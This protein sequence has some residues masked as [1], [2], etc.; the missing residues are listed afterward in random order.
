MKKLNLLF[1][2]FTALMLFNACQS[3]FEIK[4]APK[5]SYDMV[6]S[7]YNTSSLDSIIYYMDP[8][9]Y[10]DCY[11]KK[12]DTVYN[13]I[14]TAIQGTY[15]DIPPVGDGFW[16]GYCVPSVNICV[17]I[18]KIRSIL[19]GPCPYLQSD[20]GY[21]PNN[22]DYLDF[23]VLCREDEPQLIQGKVESLITNEN[24]EVLTFNFKQINQK[25]ITYNGEQLVGDE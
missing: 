9:Y 20:Y 10:N 15:A 12:K 5:P 17:Y 2:V 19:P 14:I 8:V 7:T 4:K 25:T 23:M 21:D 24:G 18:D 1:V 16:R 6:Y 11:L 3:D 13:I 22:S